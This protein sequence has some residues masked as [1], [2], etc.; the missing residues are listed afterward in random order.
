MKKRLG[1]RMDF[2][3]IGIAA[4]DEDIDGSIGIVLGK[5]KE[6]RLM[7]NTCIIYTADHGADGRRANGA[8]TRGKG[9]VWEG[10]LRVPL[11]IAGPGLRAG[12][13]SHVRASTVDLLPTIAE[14]AGIK[15][16]ALPGGFEGGSLAGVLKQGDSAP[17]KRAREEFVV[18]FPH[19]DKDDLGPA[20]AILLGNYKM[21]RFFEEERRR[22]F[23]LSKD[24]AEQHDLAGTKPEIVAAMDKRLAEYLALVNAS[25]PAP[26]P[27]YDPG[28]GRSGDRKGGGR[29][30]PK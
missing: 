15:A 8:L 11:L 22:L 12:A 6:L 9:T 7:G 17:V 3:R 20:S 23:D 24:I 2:Q 10:G 30:P 29:R 27:N 1:N 25:V 21:I 14:L 5:L 28:G 4:G 16:D 26:N 19:Y 13:F 18:H